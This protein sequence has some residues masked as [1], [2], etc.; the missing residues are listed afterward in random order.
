MGMTL[1]AARLGLAAI[2][3]AVGLDAASAGEPVAI[4]EDVAA[5]G[6]DLRFMDYVEEGRV[7]E[8]GADGTITLGYLASC[9]LEEIRGGRVV[10]GRT[11]S[12]VENGEVRRERVLCDGGPIQLSAAEADK[13]G[14]TVFRRPAGDRLTLYGTSPVIQLAGAGGP[15]VI[16]RF[17]QPGERHTLSV[18]GGYLDLSDTGTELT[19]G[20]VYR[21]TAGNVE[22]IFA[23]NRF[24]EAGRAPVIG[25]LLR[26]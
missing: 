4:V 22:L 10:V 20:G 12:A 18:P 9:W 2:A 14:V 6:A 19:R 16:E 11:E 26:F 7:I 8:L 25:R 24:A 23:I 13:S 17:D 21:A 3:V 15:V 5:V 1:A